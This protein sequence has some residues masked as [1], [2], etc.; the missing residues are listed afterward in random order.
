M[1]N[2]ALG[3]VDIPAILGN[4]PIARS[5]LVMQVPT[6]D[7]VPETDGAL[8]EGRPRSSRRITDYQFREL[9]C[10]VKGQELVVLSLIFAGGVDGARGEPSGML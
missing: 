2:Q 3:S 9:S 5:A 6:A 8:T 1:L 7:Q 10:L 4:A